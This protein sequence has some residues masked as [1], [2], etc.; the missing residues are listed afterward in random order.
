M[1]PPETTTLR[2]PVALRDEIARIAQR[3]GSTMLEVVTD[4]VRRL[5]Q[6]EWWVA[7]HVT[8]D[9]LEADP[10]GYAAETR[11]L[12]HASSDGLDVG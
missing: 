1:S 12:D 9:A 3:R 2:V 11:V 7:V 5:R 8:L 6:D 4:A 10:E